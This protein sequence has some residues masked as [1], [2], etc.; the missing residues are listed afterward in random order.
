MPENFL[1]RAEIGAKTWLEKLDGRLKRLYHLEQLI[2]LL[3]IVFW[4]HFW[5][6]FQ[7]VSI[8]NDNAT[9]SYNSQ[10]ECCCHG[11]FWAN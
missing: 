5:K 9:K 8:K 11:I 7:R 4:Q 6:V 1:H 2:E 3:R 10:V